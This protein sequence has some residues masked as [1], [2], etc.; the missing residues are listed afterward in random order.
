M[1][2]LERAIALAAQAHEGQVDKAG[3][4]Y[5]LHPLRV[6]LGVSGTL[7]RIVAVLHDVLE[8]TALTPQALKAQGFSDEVLDALMSVTRRDA[9]TYEAF[10]HRCAAHP[11][12]RVVKL[13]D[14]RDNAD[15]SRIPNPGPQDLQ[16]QAKYLAAI[17]LLE[18][19]DGACSP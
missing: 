5:I 18:Q 7:P 4:P 11:A 14:L 3:A 9:E 6:M 15:L 17:R 2:T 13:A 16:R 8:D 10:V 19:G 1:A 12:G